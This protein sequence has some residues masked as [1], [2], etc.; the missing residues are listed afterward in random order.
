MALL[1][2]TA[3]TNSKRVYRPQWDGIHCRKL[4]VRDVSVYNSLVA[5]KLWQQ[6]TIVTARHRLVEYI[7]GWCAVV[8]CLVR[9]ILVIVVD[10]STDLASIIGPTVHPTRVK[11]VGSNFQ[12][13]KPLFDVFSL[14]PVELTA[15]V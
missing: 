6:V 7:L 14:M 13:L 3:I 9:P 1:L 8:D 15:E 12:R 11:A 2:T 5:K 4:P 10:K